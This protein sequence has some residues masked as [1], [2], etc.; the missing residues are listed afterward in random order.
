MKIINRIIEKILTGDFLASK[1]R[2]LL[3]F[4]GGLLVGNELATVDL[5]AQLV[6]I[7]TQLFT[8]ETFLAGIGLL[9]VAE[10]SSA[11]NKKLRLN[12]PS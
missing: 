2:H 10:R 4:V 12:G 7:L 5:A 1:V 3:G 11:I 6:D 8:S 9:G